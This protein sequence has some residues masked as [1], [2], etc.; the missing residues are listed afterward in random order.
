MSAN[1]RKT[2]YSLKSPCGH[3]LL[4]CRWWDCGCTWGTCNVCSHNMH[5]SECGRTFQGPT[6]AFA[7]DVNGRVVAAKGWRVDG[8]SVVVD[9]GYAAIVD[10]QGRSALIRLVADTEAKSIA[11]NTNANAL[12]EVCR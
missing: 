12:A 1:R 4:A 9:A 2:A 5:C 7:S 8:D 6:R 11:E 10:T 3:S